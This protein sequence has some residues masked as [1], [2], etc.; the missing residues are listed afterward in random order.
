MAT[1]PESL[2]LP[3]SCASADIPQSSLCP[4][5]SPGQS[6]QEVGEDF[7]PGDQEPGGSTRDVP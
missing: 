5:A 7:A 3:Q 6:N 4:Q 1:L 2:M